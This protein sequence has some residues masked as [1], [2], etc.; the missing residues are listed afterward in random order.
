[1][2][3]APLGPSGCPAT[4]RRAAG[5]VEAATSLENMRRRRLQSVSVSLALAPLFA[6]CAAESP[7]EVSTGATPS[8]AAA[9]TAAQEGIATN[10]TIGLDVDADITGPLTAVPGSD[11]L[12]GLGLPPVDIVITATP[13][14]LPPEGAAEVLRV[15]RPFVTADHGTA[16]QP[17]TF[18]APT[19][20]TDVFTWR[21]SD[22]VL[23]APDDAPA[24]CFA[25]FG[26]TGLAGICDNDGSQLGATGQLNI[27][28]T[29]GPTTRAVASEL[30]ADVLA[31][32][33]AVQDMR[34]RSEVID[35]F[36]YFEFPG[37]QSGPAIAT[38]YYANGESEHINLPLLFP[39]AAPP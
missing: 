9:I 12:V 2:T 38:V 11:P 37:R 10:T 23:A 5:G 34:V 16:R 22:P 24:N 25:I 21:S 3:P 6:A 4:L 35:G 26:P 39:N 20:D 33:L 29:D 36:A 13:G 1:M 32:D 7:N 19:S 17:V 8:S 28:S 27:W 18:H 31:V 14:A 30:A 15:Q